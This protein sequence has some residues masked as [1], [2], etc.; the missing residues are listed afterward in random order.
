LARGQSSSGPTLGQMENRGLSGFTPTLH[1]GLAWQSTKG[2]SFDA[3]SYLPVS[4]RRYQV[5]KRFA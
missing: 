4:L 2:P 3:F 5:M 1:R